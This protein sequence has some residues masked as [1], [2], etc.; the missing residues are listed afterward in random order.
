[1]S[2]ANDYE[3]V[4]EALGILGSKSKVNNLLNKVYAHS[5]D[6]QL[7][8]MVGAVLAAIPA[9]GIN[10]AVITLR[11]SK[12]IATKELERYCRNVLDWKPDSGPVSIK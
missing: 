2:N 8:N 12:S 9:A 5:K 11:D 7:R 6:I 4:L 1:M 10:H 3:D